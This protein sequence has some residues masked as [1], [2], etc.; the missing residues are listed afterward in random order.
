MNTGDFV[1]V[2]YLNADED[3]EIARVE[4]TTLFAF[5]D[6]MEQSSDTFVIVI[7]A[8][9]RRKAIKKG[10]IIEFWEEE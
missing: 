8:D 3:V 9:G 4:D 5:R 10:S 7:G 1:I 6:Y 2:S